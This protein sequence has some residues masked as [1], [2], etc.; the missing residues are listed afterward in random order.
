[1]TWVC[2]IVTSFVDRLEIAGATKIRNVACEAAPR[3]RDVALPAVALSATRPERT[4]WKKATSLHV[5]CG[6]GR[7][8]DA[9]HFRRH[10]PGNPKMLTVTPELVKRFGDA[11]SWT[12]EVWTIAPRPVRRQS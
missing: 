1:M 2:A 10:W 5:C 3:L 7:V 11:C 4:S 8:C 12:Y 9:E 6:D